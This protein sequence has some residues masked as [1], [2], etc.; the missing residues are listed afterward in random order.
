[1]K[2]ETT[3]DVFLRLFKKPDIH[4]FLEYADTAYTPV[5]HE[6][7]RQMCHERNE[8]QEHIIKRAGI[9]RTYGHQL[10]NGTR[11][12][13]RDKVIQLAFGF[14]MDVEETQKLLKIAQKSPLY[15][16]VK[17]DAA[18]IYC[19]VHNMDISETQDILEKVDVQVLGK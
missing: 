11:N 2:E 18:I 19:I 3:S 12:P 8:K 7:I 4:E 15:V 6:Y 5:F 17:R 1:M 14:G 10:F 13:S 16:K 9:E